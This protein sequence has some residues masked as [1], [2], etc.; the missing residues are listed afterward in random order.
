MNKYEQN[1]IDK[2]VEAFGDYKKAMIWLN[3]PHI[4]LLGMKPIELI[5]IQ[6]GSEKVIGMLRKL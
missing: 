2:A 4:K 6:I 5:D 3:T 1:A